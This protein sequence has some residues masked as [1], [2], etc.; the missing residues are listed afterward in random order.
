[1][2]IKKIYIILIPLL[3]IGILLGC[4]RVIK[5]HTETI[6]IK[7]QEETRVKKDIVV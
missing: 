3:G 2:T 7:E 5:T 4:E 6:V 1:M